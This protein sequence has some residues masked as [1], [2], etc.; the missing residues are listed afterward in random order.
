MLGVSQEVSLAR[1]GAISEY[2]NQ[3]NCYLFSAKYI[4]YKTNC[5]MEYCKI[6]SLIIYSE[7]DL[8][9]GVGVDG[10]P[11]NN[12]KL[13]SSFCKCEFWRILLYSPNCVA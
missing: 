6:T 2:V 12:T 8:S 1:A 7:Q 9:L 11:K 4:F 10:K 13:I 3:V 5:K